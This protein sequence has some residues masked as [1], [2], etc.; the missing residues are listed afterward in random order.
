MNIQAKPIFR[1]VILAIIIL[2]GST[3]SNAA[4]ASAAVYGNVV[5]EGYGSTANL[6]VVG[7][8]SATV[9]TMQPNT[10]SDGW[11]A[12]IKNVRGFYVPSGYTAVSRW[13]YGY[14]G[15]Y[16]YYFKTSYNTLYLQ[17]ESNYCYFLR[18]QMGSPCK[19]PV[20]S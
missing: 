16:W 8:G 13:G 5:I 18:T 2:M 14:K 10:S 17:V 19:V 3:I 15:G 4:P 6:K 9:K 7:E 12:F 1:A 20:P 11:P